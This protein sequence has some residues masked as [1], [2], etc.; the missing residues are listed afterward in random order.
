MSFIRK[1]HWTHQP[2]RVRK[3]S[4]YRKCNYVFLNG[5]SC[6]RIIFLSLEKELGYN[7][8]SWEIERKFSINKIENEYEYYFFYWECKKRRGKN[9][10]KIL[11]FGACKYF[12]LFFA[13]YLL[14]SMYCKIFHQWFNTEKSWCCRAIT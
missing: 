12:I 5:N 8:N 13:A 11:A 4:F 7:L 3:K 10:Q 9:Q 6:V 14:T 2:A 1:G